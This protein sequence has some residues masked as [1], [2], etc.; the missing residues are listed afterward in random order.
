MCP[1]NKGVAKCTD[2]PPVF[3]WQ[4]DL[5]MVQ[6]HADRQTIL[7]AVSSFGRDGRLLQRPFALG[8]PFP[9]GTYK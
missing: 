9:G 3:P 4:E 1:W 2:R 6:G 8:H 5:V 7:L